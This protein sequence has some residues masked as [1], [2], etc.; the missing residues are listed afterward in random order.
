MPRLL[1][2]LRHAKSDWKTEAAT[3]FERPLSKRGFTD[4]PKMAAWL[5]KESDKP[6]TIISS[7][8]LRAYQ[9]ALNFSH[10]L[11]VPPQ[12]ICFDNRI[13]EAGLETLLEIVKAIPEQ[14]KSVLLIG[15]NPGL[16][17]LLQALCR[18]AK[19]GSDGKL[20]TTCAIAKITIESRWQDVSD[21]HCKL[22]SLSRPKEIYD[23]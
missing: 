22:S 7:P 2:L 12:A 20:M 11:N 8:A 6:I 19:P 4:A 17:Y 15:H 16:D 21:K 9:T 13:Y 10:A 14:E 5:A 3:D 23:Q 1:Y 18:E